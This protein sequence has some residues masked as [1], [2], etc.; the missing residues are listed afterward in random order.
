VAVSKY[1]LRSY[2]CISS[3]GLPHKSSIAFLLT[4][5]FN[6]C[7]FKQASLS[8]S[9]LCIISPPPPT[10]EKSLDSP[11]TL[12]GIHVF[13][14]I[15]SF[16]F[17][18]KSFMDFSKRNLAKPWMTMRSTWTVTARVATST[19]TLNSP[20]RNSYWYWK[21]LVLVLVLKSTGAGTGTQKWPRD[22]IS[23]PRSSAGL[24]CA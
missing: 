6:I 18:S 7:R 8:A 20:E 19:L 23:K 13:S 21:V 9:W 5:L 12:C 2:L 10:R 3:R 11:R 14:T 24:Q 16:H 17:V 4:K 15:P 22:A 1:W